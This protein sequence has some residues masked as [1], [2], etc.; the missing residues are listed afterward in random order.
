[1]LIQTAGRPQPPTARL[2]EVDLLWK[3]I[4]VFVATAALKARHHNFL[5][6]I[7]ADGR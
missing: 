1:M 6:K 7:F 5:V 2:A 3:C 4:V